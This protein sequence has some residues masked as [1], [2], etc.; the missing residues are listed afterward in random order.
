MYR[1]ISQYVAV[2][3]VLTERGALVPLQA[4]QRFG[5]RLHRT[6]AVPSNVPFRTF[7][8]S[9]LLKP[10]ATLQQSRGEK[11]GLRGSTSL[12]GPKNRLLTTILVPGFHTFVRQSMISD[13]PSAAPFCPDSLADRLRCHEYFQQPRNLRRSRPRRL[14][15]LLDQLIADSRLYKTGQS[16]KDLLEFVTRLRNVAPFNALL[17]QLQKPGLTYAASAHDW[18]TRFGRRPKEARRPMLILWP[19]GPVATVFDVHDMEGRPLPED[20]A[21]FFTTGSITESQMSS[22]KSRLA[23]KHIGWCMVDTGDAKAGKIK[24]TKRGDSDTPT[25]YEIRINRNHDTATQFAT[26]AHELGHLFLGHLGMDTRLKVPRRRPLDHA[27]VE[28][29]Q[30]QSPTSSAVAMA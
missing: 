20:V 21:S 9:S 2:M 25:E 7:N 24:V 3:I 12:D 10:S 29:R 15:A 18:Q 26:L 11:L 19:F 5:P 14:R 8:P 16:Y 6:S 4:G 28:S 22:I 1:P 17:L 23:T 13:Y 27:G 30:S